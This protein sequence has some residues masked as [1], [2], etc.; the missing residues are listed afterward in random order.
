MGNIQPYLEHSLYIGTILILI[1]CGFGLPIPEEVTF[2]G[3]G[4]VGSAHGA[5]VWVLSACGLFGIMVGDSLTFML[6]RNVGTNLLRHKWLARCL[7]EK[8]IMR[9]T[10]FFRRRGSKAIF[11]ARFVAGVRVRY[12]TFFFWDFLGALISCPVSIWLAYKFGEH[13]CYY[14]C[15]C[16]SYLGVILAGVVVLMVYRHWRGSC[17]KPPASGPPAVR[18]PVPG[19]MTKEPLRAEVHQ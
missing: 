18:V 6:G 1:L 2:L 14:C 15:Q 11:I 4:L 19:G 17:V 5:N 8:N 12:R 3:A 16:K 13:G 10:D 9:T 7:S